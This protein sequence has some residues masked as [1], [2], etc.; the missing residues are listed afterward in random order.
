MTQLRFY[1]RSF[2]LSLLVFFLALLSSCQ[3]PGFTAQT[4]VYAPIPAQVRAIIGEAE[5]QGFLGMLA[6]ADAIRNRGSLRGVYGLRSARVRNHLYSQ[7][8]LRLATKAWAASASRDVT[9][10]ATGWGSA[11]DLFSFSKY[12]WWASCVITAHIG[13]HWFYREVK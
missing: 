8:T 3:E 2:G 11:S 6:I 4:P 12:S 5:N 10:S 7:Q 13:D 1:L 9:G